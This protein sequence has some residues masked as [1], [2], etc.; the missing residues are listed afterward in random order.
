MSF[1]MCF[2][3]NSLDVFVESF[4]NEFETRKHPVQHDVECEI[5][6][7]GISTVLK[8]LSGMV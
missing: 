3:N 1:T 2:G 6:V 7:K 4:L 8:I 5:L